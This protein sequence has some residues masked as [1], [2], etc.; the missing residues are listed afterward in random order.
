MPN[1]M[2]I[3][4]RIFRRLILRYRVS[5]KWLYWQTHSIDADSSVVFI[6]G[7]QRS[8]TTLLCNIF[9]TD[10]R[11]S[12]FQENS[13]ITGTE[14]GRLRMKPFDQVQATFV[15]VK[16]PLIVAK[17]LVES[18]K[19][20]QLLR[21]F[22]QSRVLWTYRQYKD[23]VSSNVKKFQHQIRNLESIV[24]SLPDDW[25]AE[26]VSDKT[27]ALISRLYSVEMS[28]Y[29]AAALFWYARNILFFELGLHE[30]PSV[31]LCKYENLVSNPRESIQNIYNFIEF[32]LPPSISTSVREVVSTSIGLG[33]DIELT[34]EVDKLCAELQARLDEIWKGQ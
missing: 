30:H 10:Y 32:A 13:A 9:N 29:D 2:N 12:L 20:I 33:K 18:Q 25:R 14:H 16:T 31:R 21:C 24:K 5:K 17:P 26:M 6:L 4:A 7:C 11:V 3:L 27:R 23:V 15:K 22:P 1:R 8:G 28:R 19:A 34:D